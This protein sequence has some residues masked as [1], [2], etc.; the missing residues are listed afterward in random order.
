MNWTKELSTLP[1]WK[2]YSQAYE[3]TYISHILKSIP[4]QI[5]YKKGDIDIVELGAWDGFHL[6]NTRHFIEQGYNALLIDGDNH[7]NAEVKEHFITKENVLDILKQYKT[8]SHFDMLCIDLDGND[9]YI[10]EEI[11]LEYQPSL[12]VA[13]YNPIFALGES[14]TITYDPSHNWNHDDYYGFSFSAGIKLAKKHNY[15]CIFQ[16][17]NLNMYFVKNA[18]LAESLV[19]EESEI[20]NH[21]SEVTYKQSNYHPQSTKTTWVEY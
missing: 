11:L 19:I 2:K 14:R 13:E 4:H 5:N 12:I 7:G 1:I 21:L 8:P 9:L 15:T 17:D 16:N 3:E 10:L 6:S 18:V 20:P